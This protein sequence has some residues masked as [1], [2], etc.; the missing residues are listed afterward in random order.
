MKKFLAWAFLAMACQAPVERV[1]QVQQQSYEDDPE[2]CG[3]DGYACFGGRTCEDYRCWPAWLPLEPSNEGPAPRFAAGAATYQG[4]YV[5]SGG[6]LD[7][8][9][10]PASDETWA[11]SPTEN[12][13]EQL[14]SL[15][16][17]RA[18][19]QAITKANHAGHYVFG[20]S[21]TCLELT[22][23]L[24]GFARLDL[25]EE[26]WTTLS[27]PITPGFNRQ[28]ITYG[29]TDL[30]MVFGGQWFGEEAATE[31]GRGDPDQSS[32]WTV[33]DCDLTGCERSG[34]YTFYQQDDLHIRVMG[35]NSL[36]GSAPDG[37]Q[38]AIADDQ[39]SGWSVSSGAPNFES[40]LASA[41]GG[42][43]RFAT[44]GARRF[45]PHVFGGA[46][47]QELSG[48]QWVLD[49]E[50]PP[51][52]YCQEGPASWIDG[53]LYQ[54][55]GVCGGQISEIGVRYQPPAPGVVNSTVIPLPDATC[56]G[57]TLE[58]CLPLLVP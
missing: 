49:L 8:G 42:P 4:R 16:Y 14:P 17:E 37:V 31:W 1:G 54:F 36:Y 15:D 43:V 21:S 39:W 58:Q 50:T 12:T 20:G 51:A 9:S 22:S 46:L 25:A 32:G 45:Y 53:E 26:Q 2:N 28:V 7:T 40:D 27:T 13:W 52:G 5:V 44:N 48:D 23:P 18:Y 34:P 35:G 47:V 24:R 11:Y 29:G 41:T 19:H 56:E 57:L 30:L 6:C 10:G 3:A 33:S 55:S 38:M